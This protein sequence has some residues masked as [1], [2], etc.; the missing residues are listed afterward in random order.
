M[1]LSIKELQSPKIP[2]LAWVKKHST[3]FAG[4]SFREE[5]P[6]LIADNTRHVVTVEVHAVPKDKSMKEKEAQ[7]PKPNDEYKTRENDENVHLGLMDWEPPNQKIS[8]SR[9]YT[10]N[11]TP[12]KITEEACLDPDK[13][14]T[15]QKIIKSLPT[16]ADHAGK[17]IEE[18]HGV[19]GSCHQTRK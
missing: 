1:T 11:H 12:G 10:S 8:D 4:T 19:P 5:S 2:R 14:S 13:K 16:N 3:D 17:V 9:R 6:T 18:Q 15:D 7:M